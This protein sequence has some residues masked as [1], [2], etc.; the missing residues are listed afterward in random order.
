MR[1]FA[2]L[3]VTAVIVAGTASAASAHHAWGSYHWKQTAPEVVLSYNANLSGAWPALLGAPS[4]AGSVIE[5]WNS[6]SVLDLRAGATNVQ[7]AKRCR[8]RT[9]TIQICNASY[10]YNGWLGIAQIWTSGGHITQATAKM[11][12][13]YFLNYASYRDDN[14][15]RM[16][17]CQE[18]GH[19]FGLGHQ[20]EDQTNVNLGT[21]MDYTNSPL[22][23][24][25]NLYPNSHDYTQLECVYDR[26]DYTTPTAHA[27][28]CSSTAAV[29]TSSLGRSTYVEDLGGGRRLITHVLW[30][31]PAMARRDVRD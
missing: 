1:R 30:A 17:L 23:P 26:H 4:V 20:D 15:R 11:N 2:V 29:S 22:G 5:K 3:V 18:V 25:S 13:S 10:G 24:P 8:A 28:E 6:S 21:C 9:N 27:A 14:W 19:D 7:S 12:D 31:D 16:V